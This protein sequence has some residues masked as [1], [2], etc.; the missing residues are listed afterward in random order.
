[1]GHENC[2]AIQA[3]LNKQDETIPEIAALVKPAVSIAAAESGD[4]LKNAVE[5]NVK[6][7]VSQLKAMDFID[8]LIKTGD[9][10]VVGSYYHLQNGL[11]RILSQ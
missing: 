5:A 11:V 9:L 4:P 1:M 3:V 10:Q 6:L 2:G 8:K 7:V